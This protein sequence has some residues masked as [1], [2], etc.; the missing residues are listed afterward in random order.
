[1]TSGCVIL[2]EFKAS[3]MPCATQSQRLIPA[4]ILISITFTFGSPEISLKAF[5]NFSG[6]AP[7]PTSRKFAG[8]PPPQVESYPLKPLLS[9]HH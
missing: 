3:T 6:V 9:Q 4:K 5:T 8:F 1:M 2:I 7:P